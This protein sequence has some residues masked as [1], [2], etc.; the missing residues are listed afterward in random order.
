MDLAEL[1]T[2]PHIDL[3]TF[4]IPKLNQVTAT[5]NTPVNVISTSP[6]K[7]PTHSEV[8]SNTDTDTEHTVLC[9]LCGRPLTEPTSRVLGMGPSCYKQFKA[10][11]SR[12]INLFCLRQV[13]KG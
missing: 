7:V 8:V 6:T 5:T 11:H 3:N 13:D 2:Y 12:Q 4:T 1:Y 9:R 10:S